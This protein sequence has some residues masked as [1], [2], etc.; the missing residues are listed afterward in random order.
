MKKPDHSSSFVH[1]HVHTH[2]SLLKSY[3]HVSALVKK[4]LEFNQKALAIT[5][6]GNMY[7]VFDLYF[8][9]REYGIKPLLG[10]E[11]FVTEDTDKKLTP[12]MVS[13]RR[14]IR[15]ATGT[16]VLIAKNLKGYHN[17]CQIGTLGFREGFYYVPRISKEKLKQY[18]EGLFVLS[19]GLMSESAFLFETKGHDET[20]KWIEWLAGTFAD[21][22]YLELCRVGGR[23][24]ARYND[25]L[26]ETGKIKRLPV[27]AAN[28]VHFLEKQDH[29]LQ[30][31]LYCIGAN[32][33]LK[34]EERFKLP[35]DQYYFKSSRQMRDT[36]KDLPSACDNTL[37]LADRCN[38]E[39]QLKDKKGRQIY[40]LPKIKENAVEKK[41]SLSIKNLNR[42]LRVLSERGLEL[43]FK[44]IVESLGEE[45]SDER[46]KH[47]QDR[48]K[49]ELS[50]I[51]K[52]GFTDYFLIVYD[53]VS[54][55][56]EQGIPVGPGRGSGASSLV[57]YSL[58][59]TN[60]DPMPH[61]LLFERFLNPERVTLPDFDI[62]FC[63][64][65]RNR[66]IDYV[67]EK[68]GSDY[69]TQVMTYGRLQARAAIRDVGRVLGMSFAEVDKVARLVSEKPGVK[70]KETLSGEGALK[71][72]M[73]SDPQVEALINFALKL[74][75]LIRHVSIHAAG[76]II[77]NKPISS[78]APLYKGDDGE[79]VIQT[80][81]SFSKKMGLVK[82]DFLGLKTLTQIHYA[83]DM[84]R[85]NQG[86]DINIE[87]I[88]L[89]D[90]GIYDIMS[91]GFTKGVFQFEGDG[92]TSLIKRAKPSCFNDIVAVNALYRPGP[93][94]MIP[95]YLNRKAGREKAEYMFSDLE[96]ILKETYGV[97]VYQEQVLL[98]ASKIAGYSYAEA[99]VLR[100][101]MG[102]KKPDVMKKQKSRFLRG[103]K[104]NGYPAGKSEKL[105]DLVAEFARYG[106]NKSHAA[107]YCVL[108]AQT[109][110]LKKY[111]PVEFYASLFTVEVGNQDKLMQYVLEC[112]REKIKVLPPHI[113]HSGRVFTPRGRSIYFS[114][115]AIRGVGRSVADHI[116]ECRSKQKQE[117]FVSV[118]H[119]FEVVECKRLNKTCI[120]GL[121][122]AGAFDKMGM[123][124]REV[125][126]HY[127]AVLDHVERKKR[128][129]DSG[130]M[131]FFD[132]GLE[133]HRFVF[134]RLPEYPLSRLLKMEREVLGFY[135]SGHPLDSVKH[136]KKMCKMESYSEILLK[137]QV[138]VKES[139]FCLWGLIK[140]VREFRTKKGQPMAIIKLEEEKSQVLDVVIF[141]DHFSKLE[142]DLNTVTEP[143]VVEG[144][145]K[146]DQLDSFVADSLYTLGTR[147]TKYYHSLVLNLTDQ[148]Y[149]LSGIKTLLEQYKGSFPL[150]LQVRDQKFAEKG[151]S[152]VVLRS[153]QGV[154]INTKF[155]EGLHDLV[156]KNNV[157]LT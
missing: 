150:Y 6:Y 73:E 157:L 101:A 103:A 139:R 128:D 49:N 84:I 57:A 92:I 85:N 47:Y 129:R 19:G 89:N 148:S 137:E 118:E 91:K 62:D 155:L 21:H 14:L 3:C 112:Q 4:V 50:I 111:H 126:E 117:R 29:I 105:F 119:F 58:K 46:K 10:M 90:K 35:S 53:F 77:A 1:L 123:N 99:D 61:R 136:Y 8:T 42:N 18:S 59:I 102:E 154:R 20:F 79:N 24:T 45:L 70:L 141:P 38:V 28:D 113:N 82:F 93:M 55:A 83:Q 67:S 34:D 39:F 32:K 109:A 22:C 88:S 37:E 72:M 140:E 40:H 65:N 16:V 56:R 76:V 138:N 5:D 131:N 27:V 135:L 26:L 130:Q 95:S 9:A 156:G 153:K 100:R 86:K 116:E 69:V 106:F 124:R 33:I 110:W 120:E 108:A 7:G 15:G 54:W 122:K 98:I 30:D 64:E 2:Y 66:V 31:V 71:E 68:Y 44:E 134:K 75:G 23:S 152:P 149:A 36:F 97:I 13:G 125:M 74:E 142:Y 11:I 51:T 145:F 48:L 144:R 87:N 63:Q 143:V 96:P 146:T 104:Q 81:L 127:P 80:D 115:T 132:A 107:A 43:R 12:M 133:A 41:T 147:L 121:I 78:F 52:M 17:L 94:D 151:V 25:F 60:L 114:F